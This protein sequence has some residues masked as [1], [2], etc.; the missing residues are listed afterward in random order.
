MNLETLRH[1]T[2]LKYRQ[3]LQGLSELRAREAALRDEIGKL[4][5]SAFAAQ[6]LP[7]AAH[8]MRNI[9]ADMIWLR[10][11]S[12][13]TRALNLE[14][15]QVLAEKEALLSRQR[16]AL[17]RKSV[18]DGLAEKEKARARAKGQARRLAQA[19]DIEVT[20]RARRQ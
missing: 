8:S 20:Q 11:V 7:V 13:A 15:A 12:K 9:G 17:G 5:E 19:I 10:W 14:L 3:S 1:L 16:R 2:D 6:S 4:R 18:A